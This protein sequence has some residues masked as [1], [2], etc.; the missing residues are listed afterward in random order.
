MTLYHYTDQNGFLGIFQNEELWATKIQYLNDNNEFN[1]AIDL[2]NEYLNQLLNYGSEHASKSKIHYYINQLPNIMDM[3]ICVCSL[4]ENGD[5]LSQWR[6]YSSSLGGYSIGFNE[7]ALDP[8]I[9]LSN[10]TLSKCIYERKEQ[11]SLIR[12]FIDSIIIKSSDEPNAGY[13]EKSHYQSAD[14][15]LDGLAKMAPTLKDSS[16]SE[17][18]EWRIISNTTFSEL[19]FRAGKSMLTPFIKISLDSKENNDFDRLIDKIIIGHTPHPK[20]AK[21]STRAFILN[22]YPPIEDDYTHTSIDIQISS[23]PYRN[24]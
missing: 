18:A 11:E 12:E 3:N 20:L 19:E 17:E 1:L 10:L 2:A 22:L 13:Q 7:L 9:K 4:T 21:A 6:G 24:W 8:Y 16:F 5:L 14:D 23:I 15:F